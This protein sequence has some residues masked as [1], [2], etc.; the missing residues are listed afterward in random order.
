MAA[1]AKSLDE[2]LDHARAPKSPSC[3]AMTSVETAAK[4]PPGPT[5]EVVDDID[6]EFAE[7]VVEASTTGRDELFRLVLTAGDVARAATSGWRCTPRR[8][9][10]GGWSTCG[11]P[12]T[13]LARR[14]LL[15]QVGAAY[16]R[17]RPAGRRH[18]AAGRQPTRLRRRHVPTSC[19]STS[20][21]TAA[22]VG[23]VPVGWTPDAGRRDGVRR[24]L[25]AGAL[26]DIR[27]GAGGAGQPAERARRGGPRRPRRGRSRSPPDRRVLRRRRAP[28]GAVTTAAA[29]TR[30]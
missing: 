11:R 8:R 12:D 14:T 30:P 23:P 19:T 28:A 20:G 13:E 18:R 4:S 15:D 1:F 10:T 17:A 25:R 24:R 3:R 16:A 27:A 22:L 5:V 29:G 2:V 6:G 9:S 21:P 7:R 26:A